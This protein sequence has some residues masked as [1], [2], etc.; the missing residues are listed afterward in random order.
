M[1]TS[2]TLIVTVI[3]HNEYKY[4]YMQRRDLFDIS[5]FIIHLYSFSIFQ[6]NIGSEERSAKLRKRRAH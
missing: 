6:E 3:D 1:L 4:K 2:F 5:H